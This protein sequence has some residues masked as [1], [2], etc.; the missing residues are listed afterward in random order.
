ML[1]K[2]QN[3]YDILARNGIDNCKLVFYCDQIQIQYK[4]VI[5][6]IDSVKYLDQGMRKFATVRG[7]EIEMPRLI[8]GNIRHELK[9]TNMCASCADIRNFDLGNSCV[10]WP[11]RILRIQL[12]IYMMLHVLAQTCI[13]YY[14]PI[15]GL[16]ISSDYKYRG[17]IT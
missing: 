4:V 2:K 13:Q 16:I 12:S 6:S 7:S 17:N 10:C 11:Q 5:F 1:H 15:K 3:T 8:L 9:M 14:F